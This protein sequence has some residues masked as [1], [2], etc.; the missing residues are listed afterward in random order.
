MV[1]ALCVLGGVV[2][3]L[4]LSLGLMGAVTGDNRRGYVSGNVALELDGVNC[5]FLWSAEG[6]DA[7]ADVISTAA[8]AGTAR[9]KRLGP[10]K[11]R[12]ITIALGVPDSPALRQWIADAVAGRAS[13][14]NGAIVTSD[15]NNVAHSRLEFTN[16][17]IQEVVFPALDAASKD[18][19]RIT[20]TIQPEATQVKAATDAGGAATPSIG[21]KPQKRW[22]PSNFRLTIPGLDCTRVNK[23]EAI[24]IITAGAPR[25]AEGVGNPARN[26]PGLNIANFKAT[27]TEAS[28]A[29]W[30]QWLMDFV[31]RGDNGSQKAKTATLEYLAPDLKELLVK[32][33]FAGVGICGLRP[34]EAESGS[35]NIRRD[36]GEFYCDSVKCWFEGMGA[37]G[38]PATTAGT[39]E[40][41]NPTPT[42]KTVRHVGGT[43]KPPK[44]AK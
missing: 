9:H 42:P 8:A 25:P 29:S 16:A 2:L 32:L 31:V 11:Y 3:F 12:P 7:Y 10:V 20:I 40:T 19:A 38:A 30:A 26:A 14:K 36:A 37:G 4:V 35:E 18:A 13:R 17:V 41:T 22:L 24:D 15:Y 44:P 23:I 21:A 1:R 34:E 39:T 6:G 5:G 33:E 43:I 27:T 28:A